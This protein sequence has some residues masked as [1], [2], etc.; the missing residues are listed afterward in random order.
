MEEVHNPRKELMKKILLVS[1]G[2]F[3][4]PLWGRITLHRFL[5]QMDGISIEFVHSLEQLPADVDEFSALVLHYHHKRTS[6]E[7]LRRLDEYVGNGGGILALHSTTASFKQNALTYF[8]IL[9]GRF[10][11]HG[12]VEKFK[13]IN[14]NSE[15]FGGIPDFDVRDELYI[16]EMNDKNQVHFTA[17]HK[18]QEIPVVWTHLYGNGKICYAVPGHTSGTMKNKTY[19][20][21]LQ[22]GLEWV[23]E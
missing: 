12:K 7:A 2:I 19:Q 10:I 4:P 9:G 14:N 18:G 13:I 5:R 17:T 20:K 3:H 15:I 11:G 1:G 16:H 22:R 23:T 8:D 6:P 21:I